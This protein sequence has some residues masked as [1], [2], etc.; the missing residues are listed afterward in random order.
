MSKHIGKLFSGTVLFL[1]SAL[2]FSIAIILFGSNIAYAAPIQAVEINESTFP[3][4]AFRAYISGAF[5][6]N[7]DGILDEEEI[8]LARNIHCEEMGIKSLKGIEYLTELR[9]LYCMWNEIDSMDLSQ[10]TLLTGVWCSNNNFT[11]LDFS[12]NP[13]LEWVYCYDCNLTSLNVSNNPQMAFIECN[14]NPLTVLDVSHNPELEHLTCGSCELTELNLKNNPKLAHLDAF[15]NNLISI[16]VSNNPKM[17]RLDIWDNP[18]LGNVDISNNPGLQYY[19]CASNDVS[20][21]DVSNNPELQKLI[22]SY[23]DISSLD[24]SNN[25]K[26][27]CLY[28]EDNR[29]TSLNLSNNPKIHYLQ[30][31]INDIS[32]LSFENNPYLVKTYKEG[33]FNKEWYGCSWT[34]NYGGKDSTGGDSILY[35]WINEGVNINAEYK[36]SVKTGENY[37]PMDSSLNENDLLMREQ[38]AQSLYEMADTIDVVRT[39]TRFS[40]VEPYSE[41]GS[42]ILWCEE[43]AICM[44][45]PDFTS[46]TFGM[47]KYI[48]RQD[49]YFM[50]MRYSE[51][52]GLKRD[53]DFG[54][55]DDYMDYYDVD[56]EHWEAITWAATLNILVGKG[57]EGAEKD[58]LR[59]DPYGRATRAEYEEAVRLLYEANEKTAPN[60]IPIPARIN[61]SEIKLFVERFYNIILERPSEEEGLENWTKA[62]LAESRGGADVAYE[63]IHSA[64]YMGKNDSDEVYLTKLYRAFFDRLPDEAGMK[65][66]QKDLADGKGRDYV[67]NGFLVSDEY[68]AL[69]EKYGIKKDSTRTFVRRFYNIILEREDKNIKPEELDV[70]QIA[71]DS[72]SITGSDMAREWI[73]DLP[74]FK[75]KKYNDDQYL[76]ILYKVLLKRDIDPTG[77]A[78]WS[79]E[80]KN[81][82]SRAQILDCLLASDEFNDL[83]NEY[84]IEAGK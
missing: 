69:C 80:I 65:S 72:K 19:N 42:A 62:L 11:S 50:L 32:D 34:I 77:Y 84:G 28:C 47:G 13:N 82:K 12:P 60:D 46:D 61:P 54:R 4:D 79:N 20:S 35:I 64:E 7:G 17:K 37:S 73:N 75:T 43:N 51:A 44:G 68:A 5:D 74:E 81:G 63:F 66:W 2:F 67:L 1:S 41:Y 53:I 36:G 38:V 14:T 22:C 3:D 29:L 52:L 83:C 71:L 30:A 39:E 24:L 8:I 33:V 26:L 18:G 49:M 55:A 9:G 27:S 10:N 58:Q 78:C 45:Y 16:D 57:S 21:L 31:A 15:S 76:K 40:D 70:W 56:Y 6:N 25:P 23:N 48:T 59:I